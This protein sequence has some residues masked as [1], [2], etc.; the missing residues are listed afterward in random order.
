MTITKESIGVL[1]R[2][3]AGKKEGTLFV[4]NKDESFDLPSFVD[5]LHK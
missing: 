4:A 2:I 1:H 5:N 3:L